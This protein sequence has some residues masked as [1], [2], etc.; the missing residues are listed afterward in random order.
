MA[1]SQLPWPFTTAPIANSPPGIQTISAGDTTFGRCADAEE[2]TRHR[3]ITKKAN[4]ALVPLIKSIVRLAWWKCNRDRH[5]KPLST[6][7][8]LA[9]AAHRD[10]HR[11][12]H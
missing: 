8:A 5:L 4:S 1:I 11:V 3:E 10:H 2:A 7:L 6:C 9:E 12:L